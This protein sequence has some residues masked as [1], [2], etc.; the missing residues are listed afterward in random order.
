MMARRR[1]GSLTR[2]RTRPRISE[3]SSITEPTSSG[4]S[5][6]SSRLSRPASP[7]LA[8]PVDIASRNSPRRTTAGTM[9][10]EPLGSSAM[11]AQTPARRASCLTRAFT[12]GSSVAATT[13]LIPSRSSA[14]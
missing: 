13:R 11:L 6:S 1:P 2:T 4:T 14:R 5:S 8:P 9:K 3:S 10:S 7:G 12:A